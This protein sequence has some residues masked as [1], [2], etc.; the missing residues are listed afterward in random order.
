MTFIDLQNVSRSKQ[1]RQ[2]ITKMAES[3][4]LE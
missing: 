1:N 3:V 2:N 4:A